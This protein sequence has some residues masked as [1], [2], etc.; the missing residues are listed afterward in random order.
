MYEVGIIPRSRQV[1]QNFKSQRNTSGKFYNNA[2]VFSNTSSQMCGYDFYG[3]DHILF[4]TDAPLGP[5]FGMTGETA[6][7]IERMDITDAEKQKIFSA[8]PR[9][10]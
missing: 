4:G 2:A 10:Y 8:M 5:K 9:N 7:S 3:A 6:E 1:S